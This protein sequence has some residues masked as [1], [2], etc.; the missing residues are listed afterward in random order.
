MFLN[1][2]VARACGLTHVGN[3][4]AKYNRVPRANIN[5]QKRNLENIVMISSAGRNG[6]S[7]EHYFRTHF[8]N[9]HLPTSA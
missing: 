7:G 4:R 2:Y 5:A 6:E 3:A 9:V 8:E 1:L